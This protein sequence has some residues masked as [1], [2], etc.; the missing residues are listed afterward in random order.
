MAR[1]GRVLSA[2]VTPFDD[3]G[4]LDLDAA[5]TLAAFGATIRD[6]LD[7]NGLVSRLLGVVDETMQPDE[8][9]LWLHPAVDQGPGSH[10]AGGGAEEPVRRSRR[11]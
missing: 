3:E 1:F 11:S 10:P 9:W 4:K 7:L 8:A 5:R 6:D 2:M